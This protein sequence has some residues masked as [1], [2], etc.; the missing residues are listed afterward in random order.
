[1]A[2]GHRPPGTWHLATH[3]HQ[4]SIPTPDNAKTQQKSPHSVNHAGLPVNQFMALVGRYFGFASCWPSCK[5]KMAI[6]ANL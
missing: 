1:M 4:C 5:E 6:D 2:T 3:G